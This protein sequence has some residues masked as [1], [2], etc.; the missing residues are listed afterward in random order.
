[1]KTEIEINAEKLYQFLKLFGAQWE[2]NC[3]DALFPPVK[4]D[5]ENKKPYYEYLSKMYGNNEKYIIDGKEYETGKID[6]I[7]SFAYKLSEAYQYL[8]KQGRAGENNGGYNNYSFYA[9]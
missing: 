9:I 4:F 1:M 7:N 6:Y 3:M 5:K 8:R 2:N